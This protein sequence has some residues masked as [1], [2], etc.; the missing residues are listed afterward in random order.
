M[1]ATV[2]SPTEYLK[3]RRLSYASLSKPLPAANVASSVS[4]SSSSGP[5][6][7]GFTAMTSTVAEALGLDADVAVMFAPPACFTVTTPWPADAVTEAVCL[8]SEL[9]LMPLSNALAGVV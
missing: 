6:S 2:P 3:E 9:Q 7:T 8:L 1:E 4:S 5:S